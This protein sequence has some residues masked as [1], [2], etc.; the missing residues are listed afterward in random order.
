VAGGIAHIVDD[1]QGPS[2]L[3][4]PFFGSGFLPSS[5]QDPFGGF[6]SHG[7]IPIAGWS[8]YIEKY[9]KSQSKMDDFLGDPHVVGNPHLFEVPVRY[10]A[11]F[12]LDPLGF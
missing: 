7:D 2:L 11:V 10:L 1:L 3:K 9:R 5:F 8:R 4:P 12:S 6:H